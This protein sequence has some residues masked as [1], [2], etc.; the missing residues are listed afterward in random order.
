MIMNNL[1]RYNFQYYHLLC[2]LYGEREDWANRLLADRDNKA[3]IQA[4]EFIVR[5]IGQYEMDSSLDAILTG[6]TNRYVL[7]QH[8][9]KQAAT[10]PAQ[11]IGQNF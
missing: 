1:D 10:C 3:M 11:R 2:F 9:A 5:L 4:F 6:Y 8:Q 7:H